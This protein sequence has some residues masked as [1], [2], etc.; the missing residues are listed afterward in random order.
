GRLGLKAILY[1]EAATTLALVIGWL[2]V[3]SL[4]PGVGLNADPSKLDTK[5]IQTYV[6]TSKPENIMDFILNIVPNSI[7]DAFA[8]GE[9]IQVLFFSILFGLAL[10][11]LGERGKAVV[12]IIEQLSDVLMRMIAIIVRMAPL[13][14]FGAI[15]YT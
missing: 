2:I 3:R 11:Y 8:R 4:Q 6:T 14:A 5:A 15:A 1:F 12:N 7:V 9:I 10:T 13:A